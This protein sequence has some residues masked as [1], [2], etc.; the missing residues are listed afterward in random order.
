VA[1]WRA[2]NHRTRRPAS[3][4]PPKNGARLESAAI[5]SPFR[6]FDRLA[7]RVEQIERRLELRG[8]DSRRRQKSVM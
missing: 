6:R 2:L 1:R 8:F 5:G 3:A 4:R 7:E